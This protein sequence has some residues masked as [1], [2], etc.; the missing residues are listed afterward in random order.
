M[1]NIIK[2]IFIML[3]LLVA[4]GLILAVIFYDYNPMNKEIPKA[5][6][7]QMPSELSDIKE[8]LE[9]PL[10]TNEEQIIRTYELTETDLDRY[11]KTNYDAGKVNPFEDYKVTPTGDDNPTSSENVTGGRSSSGGSSG[12]SSGTSTGETFFQNKFSK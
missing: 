1:K 3:L 11:K 4:I 5:I 9:I 10:T 7:Y 12:T 6:T 8:E 2:E